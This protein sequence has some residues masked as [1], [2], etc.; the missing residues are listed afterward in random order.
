MRGPR[1]APSGAP[2]PPS[3]AGGPFHSPQSAG[4]PGGGEASVVCGGQGLSSRRVGEAEGHLPPEDARGRHAAGRGG[5][6]GVLGRGQG[7]TGALGKPP[8]RALSRG[9][10]TEGKEAMGGGPQ[11]KLPIEKEEQVRKAKAVPPERRGRSDPDRK[12]IRGPRSQGGNAFYPEVG[13][14]PRA[15]GSEHAKGKSTGPPAPHEAAPRR[16]TGLDVY[17]LYC[18]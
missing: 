11:T 18:V 4:D 8:I 3:R 16:N 17:T 13:R 7:P 9:E 2:G 12:K 5:W 6:G 10:G 14:T 1:G 15:G